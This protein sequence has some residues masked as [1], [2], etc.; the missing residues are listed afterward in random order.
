M[1]HPNPRVA[2][3]DRIMIWVEGGED[4]E[5]AQI[6]WIFGPVGTGKSAIAQTIA[7]RCL[8]A[9][10]LLAAFF[11]SPPTA[12]E[13]TPDL[14]WQHSPINLGQKFP[15]LRTSLGILSHKIL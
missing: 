5:E 10:L 15:R 4:G 11:F 2:V 14:L 12:R 13:T 7:E 8:A 1:C 9:G 6:I 3:L